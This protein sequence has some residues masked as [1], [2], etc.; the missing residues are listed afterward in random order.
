MKANLGSVTEEPT[1][2]LNLRLP[3][4]SLITQYNCKNSDI[5]LPNQTIHIRNILNFKKELQTGTKTKARNRSI[6]IS[7]FVVSEILKRRGKM[8]EE[9]ITFGED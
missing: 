6:S 8:E 3:K 5:D 9:R 7:S 4:R 2:Y 1:P